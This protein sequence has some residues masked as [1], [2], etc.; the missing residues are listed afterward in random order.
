MK[1][2]TAIRRGAIGLTFLMVAHWP[3]LALSQEGLSH[4]VIL[5]DELTQGVKGNV[6]LGFSFSY[7]NAADNLSIHPAATLVFRRGIH[8]VYL[9]T[10]S[11][12]EYNELAG[13]H[14]LEET[15]L[16]VFGGAGYR[17]SVLEPFHCEILS[18]I[19]H[20]DYQA[21]TARV[22]TGVVP[23]IAFRWDSGLI[24]VG[25]GYALEWQ[26]VHDSHK[27]DEKSWNH[28]W[29]SS[30]EL[31][32]SIAENLKYTQLASI[33]PS[34]T[35]FGNL[36]VQAETSIAVSVTDHLTLSPSLSFH[37]DNEPPT[38]VDNLDMLSEISVS[39]QL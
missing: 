31:I 25:T 24:G 23:R 13:S 1:R 32:H 5:L 38:N 7:H 22:T 11:H 14:D 12:I 8:A 15:C 4:A 19:T 10:K 27:S 20:N 35:D 39:L 36:H 17:L 26:D 6:S 33:N 16:H 34:F 3:T 30:I 2:K 9:T 37:Y 28:R 29:Y 21:L 18:K